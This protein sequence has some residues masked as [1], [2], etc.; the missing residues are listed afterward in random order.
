MRV[1]RAVRRARSL[2]SMPAII[3][4]CYL[5]ILYTFQVVFLPNR[6][7]RYRRTRYTRITAV[8]FRCTWCERESDLTLS[9]SPINPTRRP[10]DIVKHLC[11]NNVD[12]NT[13]RDGIM[14][15]RETTTATFRVKKRSILSDR[16]ARDDEGCFASEGTWNS[17]ESW[18][19]VSESQ[20][21]R[22]WFGASHAS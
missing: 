22:A 18:K 8:Q 15:P 1:T 4:L 17:Y 12:S 5:F 13:R 6:D 2:K 9:D 21:I 19:S 16:I 3:F 10:I 7:V 11:A 14:I 20:R